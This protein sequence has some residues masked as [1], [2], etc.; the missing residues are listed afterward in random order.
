M[1]LV[2]KI[3]TVYCYMC[4]CFRV[5]QITTFLLIILMSVCDQINIPLS[6]APVVELVHPPE[7]V[8]YIAFET[9][10]D[11]TF[12]CT[13]TGFPAPTITFSMGSLLLN[14]GGPVGTIAERVFRI[15]PVITPVDDGTYQVTQRL[16]VT[17]V[18]DGDS[19]TYTC[20]ASSTIPMLNPIEYMDSQDFVL[21]VLGTYEHIACR[22]ATECM[23]GI[24]LLAVFLGQ[25]A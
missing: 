6:V 3:I 5:D 13:A 18:M 24:T 4:E 20:S 19:G 10:S 8:T 7:G 12:E 14:G 15:P 1:R 2:I 23:Y 17:S 11:T 16:L 25:R 22:L 21:L 9:I